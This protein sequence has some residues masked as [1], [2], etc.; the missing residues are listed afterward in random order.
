MNDVRQNKDVCGREW[1]DK[2]GVPCNVVRG[3]KREARQQMDQ[4][5]CNKGAWTTQ[6]RYFV[7]L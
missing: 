2:F 6:S 5:F 3:L 1:M 4:S 7:G